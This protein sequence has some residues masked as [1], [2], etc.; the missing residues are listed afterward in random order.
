MNDNGRMVSWLVVLLI[1]IA[2]WTMYRKYVEAMVNPPNN[3]NTSLSQDAFGSIPQL[4]SGLVSGANNYVNPLSSG[5]SGLSWNPFSPNHRHIG[6]IPLSYTSPASGI[7]SA[8][9]PEQPYAQLP[10]S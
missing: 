6:P 2:G 4:F 8:G 5:Q 7:G 1:L 3:M 10:V 9:T